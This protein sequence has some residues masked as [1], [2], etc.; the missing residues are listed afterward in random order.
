MLIVYVPA[1]Q[2]FWL[3]PREAEAASVIWHKKM[4]ERLEG[5]A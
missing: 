5:G 3:A 1:K 2:P 4:L